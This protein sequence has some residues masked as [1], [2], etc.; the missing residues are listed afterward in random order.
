LRD[1]V[2]RRAD[3]NVAGVTEKKSE[4][5]IEGI[6]PLSLSWQIKKHEE[7]CLQDRQETRRESPGKVPAD[8]SSF[9]YI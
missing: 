5:A 9:P 6:N 8:F 4:R 2:H 1:P 3:A 7:K